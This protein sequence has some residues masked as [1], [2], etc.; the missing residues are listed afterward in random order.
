MP[1]AA[2]GSRK[3]WPSS[4]GCGRRAGAACRGCA[5][6]SRHL[7][8]ACAESAAAGRGAHAAP[9]RWR[10]SAPPHR[11]PPTPPASPR[12]LHSLQGRG[13]EARRRQSQSPARSQAMCSNQAKKKARTG[14][15]H[16]A[17]K[18]QLDG[19]LR[20]QVEDGADGLLEAEL[21]L[22]PWLNAELVRHPLVVH[23][24]DGESLGQ[25]GVG[26][27]PVGQLSG[28]EAAAPFLAA[29]RRAGA[30]GGEAALLGR[31]PEVAAQQQ[32]PRPCPSLL[33]FDLLA[34]AATEP[35]TAGAPSSR[36]NCR[37]SSAA[38]PQTGPRGRSSTP[39]PPR[40]RAPPACC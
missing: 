27:A 9:P 25:V 23:C 15:W 17:P 36:G 31:R 14:P 35:S 18:S 8:M 22:L 10:R 13:R 38:S 34:A 24:H 1:A 16:P 33:T 6:W 5:R 37:G 39:R 30:G 3:S 4:P 32:A 40:A 2:A 19:L 29:A 26:L 21:S 12:A 20:L 7:K 28:A 11:M